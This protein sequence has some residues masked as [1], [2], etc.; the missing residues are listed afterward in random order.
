MRV[1][2]AATTDHKSLL[3]VDEQDASID[4]QAAL[5]AAAPVTGNEPA[6]QRADDLVILVRRLVRNLE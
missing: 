3:S 4:K 1:E 2:I 5:L 6:D